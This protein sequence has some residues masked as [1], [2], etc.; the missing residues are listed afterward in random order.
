[1]IKEEFVK[2]LVELFDPQLTYHNKELSYRNKIKITIPETLKDISEDEHIIQNS[3]GIFQDNTL[4]V[5]I[6]SIDSIPLDNVITN[7][8]YEIKIN[9]NISDALCVKMIKNLPNEKIKVLVPIF[10]LERIYEETGNINLFDFIRTAFLG[11]CS[12]EIKSLDDSSNCF[13]MF[14][15]AKSFIFNISM[16]QN[17][18]FYIVDNMENFLYDLK[19]SIRR[20]PRNNID[21]PY[22]RYIDD[23]VQYYI[24][25]NSARVPKIKFL[26]FYN[27]LEYFFD[28]V[29][30]DDKCK[31]IQKIITSPKFNHS[32]LNHYKKILE[33]FDIKKAKNLEKTNINEFDSLKLLISKYIDLN[34]FRSFLNEYRYY[35]ENDAHKIENTKFSLL[36]SDECIVSKISKRVYQVRNALVHSKDTEN[37]RYAPRKDDIYIYNEIELIKYLAQE[38]IIATSELIK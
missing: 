29:Y 7:S 5:L 4:E 1:M 17:R 38:I 22:R 3:I 26:S 25:G 10:R 27:V 16:L 13:E 9:E 37:I 34:E 23:V 21:V 36:D 18:N 31:K 30:I 24:D 12:L 2:K 15:I 28:K 32:N 11:Y 14:Q 35:I 6:R 20:I 19:P 33:V 8:N